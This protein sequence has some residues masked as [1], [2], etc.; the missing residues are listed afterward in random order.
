M[1]SLDI[2]ELPLNKQKV[3]PAK[4]LDSIKNQSYSKKHKKK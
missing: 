3:L 1:L 2:Y 4:I